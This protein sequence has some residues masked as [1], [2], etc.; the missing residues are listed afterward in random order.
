MVK[1]SKKELAKITG[2]SLYAIDLYLCRTEFASKYDEDERRYM[3]D[4][5]FVNNL[6]ELLNI[7]KQKRNNITIDVESAVNLLNAIVWGAEL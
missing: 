4:C 1:L 3:I 2:L 7:K 5:E 6:E